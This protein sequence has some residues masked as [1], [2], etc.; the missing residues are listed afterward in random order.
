MK[1]PSKRYRIT[2]TYVVVTALAVFVT[3]EIHEFA[4]WLTGRLLGY[5]TAMTLNTGYSL[6]SVKIS[7]AQIISGAGPVITLAEAV[8]V[9]VLM[10]RGNGRWLYP[11]LAACFYC[12]LLATVVSLLHPND[13][14]RISKY[15]GIGTFTLPLMVSAF[16]FFLVYKTS[17]QCGLDKKFNAITF[18]L[19][20]VFSSII[21][22]SDQFLHIRLL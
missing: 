8:L 18:V 13:E 20:I 3:W 9:F 17:V 5:D 19:V 1:P 12:R 16:L 6:Q 15:L 21:I 10:R 7:D 22:L 4:H 11:F 2:I 14:A